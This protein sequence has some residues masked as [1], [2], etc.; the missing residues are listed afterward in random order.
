MNTM[1][2]SISQRIKDIGVLRLVGYS[3]FQ[4]L[5]SFML[6]SL[7]IAMVGGLLGCALGTLAHG[8]SV[9]SVLSSQGAGGKM[10]IFHLIVDASTLAIGT[11][12]TLLTGL[13]GGLFPSLTAMRLS[14]LETLR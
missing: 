4:V 2:A 12:I 5:V 9:T 1:Y 7:V 10:V 3:R 8:M 14:P 13:A 6:E 11:A